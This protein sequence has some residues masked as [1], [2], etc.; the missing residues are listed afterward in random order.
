[1]PGARCQLLSLSITR[2]RL[3]HDPC[4]ENC[5]VSFLRIT[6]H[7]FLLKKMFSIQV[8]VSSAETVIFMGGE[9]FITI[10]S[11]TEPRHVKCSAWPFL[12]ASYPVMSTA[13]P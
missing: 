5:E 3:L 10:W 9:Y 4:G 11:E 1:M 12:A 6:E 2:P 7:L 8:S 13:W